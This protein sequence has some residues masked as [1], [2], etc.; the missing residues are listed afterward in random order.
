MREREGG[1]K[2]KKR[3]ERKR[4]SIF[5]KGKGWVMKEVKSFGVNIRVRQSAKETEFD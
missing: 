2:V 1:G 5:A 3:K 4:R